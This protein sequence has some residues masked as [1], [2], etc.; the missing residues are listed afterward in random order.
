MD[1]YVGINIIHQ[2]FLSKLWACFSA[3]TVSWG[4]IAH[5]AKLLSQTSSFYCRTE[6]R[7]NRRLEAQMENNLRD[8]VKAL[9]VRKEQVSSK[10]AFH[11]L[12][13]QLRT[14]GHL[15]PLE[16][17]DSRLKKETKP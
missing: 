4:S 5:R 17:F 15:N 2:H 16:I 6:G 3:V 11:L 9:K 7:V 1:F 14:L 10:L 13:P 8:Q 12:P